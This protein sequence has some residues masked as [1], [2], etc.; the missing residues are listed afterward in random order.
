MV[1][2][3]EMFGAAPVNWAKLRTS[4]GFLSHHSPKRRVISLLGI[5]GKG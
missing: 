5:T 1:K 4:M 3:S 2:A